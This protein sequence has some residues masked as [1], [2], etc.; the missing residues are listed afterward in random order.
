[1]VADSAYAV[2][3]W[4]HPLQ[5]GCPITV[6]TVITRLRLD[7]ALYD[8]APERKAGQMGQPWLKGDRLPTLASLIHDPETHWERVCLNRWYEETNQEVE[9]VSQ[10]A[11]R[12]R[13]GFHHFRCAGS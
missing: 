13:N 11:I 1:M 12:Y 5:Q 2:I 9:T 8:P 3:A 4:L 6:I 10:T 7:A